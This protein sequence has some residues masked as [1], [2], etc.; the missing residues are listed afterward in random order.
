MR[1]SSLAALTTLRH[2][3]LKGIL[4]RAVHRAGIAS[5]LEPPLRRLPG[6]AEGAS[7]SA[8]GASIR[9]EARGDILLALPQG[10][11]IADVSI[12]HPLSI[13][14]LP[15][16][17]ATAGAA[18]ARRDQQKRAAYSRVELNGYTFVPFLIENYGRLGQPAMALLVVRER[19]RNRQVQDVW[20]ETGDQ[21][22][23]VLTKALPGPSMAEVRKRFVLLE[24]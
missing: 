17:A 13:N 15:A 14:T 2:D 8:D 21:L 9:V 6:L 3:I 7:T 22:V 4:R 12:I 23:D 1:C 5:T 18:A 20:V 24:T 19:V 11:T 10:I 16:A